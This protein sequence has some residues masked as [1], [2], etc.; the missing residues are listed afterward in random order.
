MRDLTQMDVLRQ[1]GPAC[2]TTCLAM[3]IRFLTGDSAITPGDIDQR[4]RRLPGM[5]SAPSDLVMCAR[6]KGLK[7]E[8]YNHNS[9]QQVKELV[10]QGIPVVPLLDLTPNNALDFQ[11][12]HWV[13]MVA[14]E[15]DDR[16]DRVVIN[17]PWGQ[18]EEWGKNEFLRQWAHLKLLGLTFGYSNY[19][20]AL[21]TPDDELPRRRVDGVAPANAV[22]KGLADVLNGF[23][24]V[25]F[26]RSP[27]GLGQILWGIFRLIYGIAYLL[28][29]NI[30]SWFKFSLKPSSCNSDSQGSRS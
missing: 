4:I 25:C 1:K 8:E 27:R 14:V 10:D 7:A 26:D 21:G 15:E 9:L 24:R 16:P 23:A 17:N 11:N 2:G 20:I 6:Q 19:F 22:I 18:Q 29:S 13:V 5:F 28:L 3:V 12:W 30:R